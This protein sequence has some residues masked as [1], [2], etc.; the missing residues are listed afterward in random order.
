MLCAYTQVGYNTNSDNMWFP[1][2]PNRRV[3]LGVPKLY[4][5]AVK[6]SIYVIG[7]R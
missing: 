1:M 5:N 6:V 3:Y 2:P 4:G 7:Y